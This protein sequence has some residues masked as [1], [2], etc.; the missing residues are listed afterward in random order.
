MT[1]KRSKRYRSAAEKVD[2]KKAYTLNEAITVLK[3]LPAPKFDQTVTL[4]FR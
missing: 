3:A 4:S 2:A 1:N